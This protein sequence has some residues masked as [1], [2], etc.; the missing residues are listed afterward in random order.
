MIKIRI[1]KILTKITSFH[2]CAPYFKKTNTRT[3]VL[4][5]IL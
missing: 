5:N 1:K 2:Q 4:D 3:L